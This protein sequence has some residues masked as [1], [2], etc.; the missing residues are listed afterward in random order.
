MSILGNADATEM[1]SEQNVEEDK[2]TAYKR[3]LTLITHLNAVLVSVHRGYTTMRQMNI[4]QSVN[5]TLSK[6]IEQASEK[7][8]TFLNVFQSEYRVHSCL[9]QI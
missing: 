8:Q 9:T 2:Q 1:S 7:D 6:N 5:F 3:I 4:V